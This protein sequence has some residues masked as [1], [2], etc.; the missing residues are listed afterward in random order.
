MSFLVDCNPFLLPARS[1]ARGSHSILAAAIC[2]AFVWANTAVA[3]NGAAAWGWGHNDNFE[4]DDWTRVERH[5]PVRMINLVERVKQLAGGRDF[6]LAVKT[7]GTVLA[8][9]ANDE[10]QIGNGRRNTVTAPVQVL[11]GA[12]AVAAGGWHSIALKSDGTVWAWGDNNAGQVGDGTNARR[13]TPVQVSNINNVVA[14]AAGSIHSMALKSDGTVWTWGGNN[15]GQLGTGTTA[16]VMSPVRVQ[17]LGGVIAIAAGEDH[18]LALKAD[19]TLWAWGDGSNGDLGNGQR[20]QQNAPVQVQGLADVK[21]ISAGGTHSLAL[22]KDGT[23]WAWGYK[24]DGSTFDQNNFSTTPAQVPDLVQVA[25]IA[26]GLLHNLAVMADGTVRAWGSNDYGQLGND[27]TAISRTPVAVHDLNKV[28]AVAAGHHHSLALTADKPA[29]A[30]D[31]GFTVVD[32][33]RL[34]DWACSPEPKLTPGHIGLQCD[35]PQCIV[36]DRV[37]KNCQSKF[38]CPGCAAGGMCPPVYQMSFEGVRDIWTVG[39]IH[40]DGTTVP[41]ELEQTS[42]GLVLSFRPSKEKFISGRIGDYVLVFRMSPKGVP[43]V[44]YDVK[45]DL[46]VDNRPTV[47][48]GR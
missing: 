18:N 43:G 27:S 42:K 38:Q 11:T 39:L 7:D 22:K 35:R 33:C 31:P 19:G 12:Q 23:V 46:K 28:V 36:V 45:T 20:R 10:G 32:A 40:A 29:L 16:P 3:Q 5:V 26:S 30:S 17:T 44:K 34:R 14:V 21:A 9:G 13:L 6:T 48:S 8:W 24:L 41:Y 1:R 47:K 15:T 2:F 37:P 25:S 4:L